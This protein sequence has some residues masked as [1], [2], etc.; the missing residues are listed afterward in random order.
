MLPRSA[1]ADPGP[2]PIPVVDQRSLA[3]QASKDHDLADSARLQPLPPEIRAL[4]SAVRAFHTLE[5]HTG[6]VL[7]MQ[8]ARQ[9]VDS[10]LVEALKANDIE[11]LARLRAVQ[12][13]GFLEE[14]R[15]VERSGAPTEELEALAGSFLP[16]MQREGWS[17]GRHVE[18]DE[19][20]R[21]AIFKQMWNAFLNL[22]AKPELA[23]SLDEQRALYAFYLTHAHPSEG[24][25][26][27]LAA[28]RAAAPDEAHCTALQAGERMATESWRLERIE[29]LAAIDPAYPAAYARGIVQAR[30]GNFAAAS[31]AFRQWLHD[32]PDGPWTLRAQNHLRAAVEA[33][34]NAP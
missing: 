28:A 25:R 3:R 15:N 13:E 34:R 26:R 18:L 11:A 10:A 17:D 24:T 30:R 5:A 14:L 6:A 29:K 4:G 2:L 1:P 20:A 32:H 12:L 27:A 9:A 16:R 21:R 22:E 7:D 31:E 33:D 23:P 8:R 19:P